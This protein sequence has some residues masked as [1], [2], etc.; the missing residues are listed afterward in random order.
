MHLSALNKGLIALSLCALWMTSCEGSGAK[1]AQA[2]GQEVCQC[3]TEA[4][5]DT[6]KRKGCD[7]ILARGQDALGI[8]MFKLDTH[9]EE[10]TTKRLGGLMAGLATCKD[11]LY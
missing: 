9:S 11:E 5:G 2:L 3:L 1:E 4:K 10:E 6:A 8:S 7:T